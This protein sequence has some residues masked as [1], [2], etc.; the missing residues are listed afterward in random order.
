MYDTL[1]IFFSLTGTSTT[2][3]YHPNRQTSP[4]LWN[5]IIG[6]SESGAWSSTLPHWSKL[7]CSPS[8][9]S[10]RICPGVWVA[11]REIWL[12]ISRML[13]AFSM[14]ALPEEHINLKDYDGLSSRSPVPFRIKMIPRDHHVAAVLGV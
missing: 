1:L 8:V 10:R 4:N 3:R 2:L 11:E 12:A 7:T 13:W 6:C 14:E 9:S 5:V